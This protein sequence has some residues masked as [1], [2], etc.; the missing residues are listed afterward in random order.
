MVAH[1]MAALIAVSIFPELNKA[2]C[3][4]M[5]IPNVFFSHMHIKDAKI[6]N[7]Q[8][9]MYSF[10]SILFEIKYLSATE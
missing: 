2:M 10:I 4:Y 6:F 8:F 3:A 9:F 1:S 5:Y 7:L